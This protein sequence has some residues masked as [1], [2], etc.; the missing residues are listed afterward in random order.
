M[1]Q[2]WQFLSMVVPSIPDVTAVN[3]L[4][5]SVFSTW[6]YRL[7]SAE[8]TLAVTSSFHLML[9]SSSVLLV[10]VHTKSCE[11]TCLLCMVFLHVTCTVL[12]T[13][14]LLLLLQGR[15]SEVLSLQPAGVHHRRNAQQICAQRRVKAVVTSSMC[16]IDSLQ[17]PL[18]QF[19]GQLV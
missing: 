19:C 14:T 6:Q 4:Y 18:A 17:T 15:C 16:L 13:R 12:M 7:K 11:A 8:G 3:F 5:Q 1:S 9:F 2:P 10:P